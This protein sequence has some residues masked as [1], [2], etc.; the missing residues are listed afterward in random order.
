MNTGIE[1][2]RKKQGEKQGKASMN[3]D[4]QQEENKVRL[5]SNDRKH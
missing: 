4:G 2:T 1:M 5:K 3:S